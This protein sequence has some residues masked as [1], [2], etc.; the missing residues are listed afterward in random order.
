[1]HFFFV[2][3]NLCKVY[4]ISLSINLLSIFLKLYSSDKGYG[5]IFDALVFQIFA[6]LSFRIEL[7]TYSPLRRFTKCTDSTIPLY[8][9]SASFLH[10]F[11]SCLSYKKV[12]ISVLSEIRGIHPYKRLGLIYIHVFPGPDLDQNIR[13]GIRSS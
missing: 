6:I 5:R 12:L 8:R 9:Y 4:K 11:F 1:M 3:V 13:A 10:Y 7:E 2:S